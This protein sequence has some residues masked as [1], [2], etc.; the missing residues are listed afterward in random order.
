MRKETF[1]EKKKKGTFCTALYKLPL[2][3]LITCSFSPNKCEPSLKIIYCHNK[4]FTTI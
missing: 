1:K 3:E 4:T 2:R